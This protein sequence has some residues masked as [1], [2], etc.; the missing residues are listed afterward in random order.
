MG[1]ATNRRAVLGAILATGAAGAG[2]ALPAVAAA[3]DHPDA[4]LFTLIE[5]AKIAESMADDASIVVDEISDGVTPAFPEAL[6][7]GESDAQHGYEISVGK[8]ISNSDVNWLRHWLAL[9][10]KPDPSKHP[11]LLLIFPKLDFIERAREIVRSKDE[12]ES[13]LRAA[14]EHPAV[15]EAKSR[16]EALIE[17]WEEFARRVARTPSKTPDGLIAKILMISSAYCEDDL[18]G[19]DDGIL[20]SA[21]LDARTLT[22]AARN[23]RS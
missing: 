15:L 2:S 17:Q 1:A 4:D 23:A 7:W 10:C 13:A 16:Y 20:A 9:P 21:A 12:F 14:K 5:R 3:S 6:I 19:S 11:D 18:E 8:P 22:N